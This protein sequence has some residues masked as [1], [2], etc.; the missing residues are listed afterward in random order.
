MTVH[1]AMARARVMIRATFRMLD[2]QTRYVSSL[3]VSPRKFCNYVFSEG[4]T[5]FPRKYGDFD[6]DV[7]HEFLA[8]VDPAR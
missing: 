7:A 4:M 1:D 8:Y 2:E 3:V 5:F 6:F